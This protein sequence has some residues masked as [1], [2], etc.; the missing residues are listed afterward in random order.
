MNTYEEIKGVY[1]ELGIKRTL[2]PPRKGVSDTSSRNMNYAQ[3]CEKYSI[4][5]NEP[6]TT[7]CKTS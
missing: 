1:Q 4:Y 5:G 3:F 2:E 7:D 6:Y